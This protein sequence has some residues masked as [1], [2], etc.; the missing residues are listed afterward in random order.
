MRVLSDDNSSRGLSSECGR[1][2]VFSDP[3]ARIL[4]LDR[5]KKS[6]RLLWA[7]A[8]TTGGI[9]E[10]EVRRVAKFATTAQ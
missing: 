2:R 5:R 9:L 10:R 6:L 1:G 3:D 7:G 8:G 4:R